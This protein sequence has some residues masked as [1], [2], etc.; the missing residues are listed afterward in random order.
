M[1]VPHPILQR[2]LRL[3]Q[4]C[5]V[6]INVEQRRGRGEPGGET[7][8]LSL[9]FVEPFDSLIDVFDAILTTAP[10]IH[11]SKKDP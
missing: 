4:S 3:L 1:F 11:L 10:C 5:H 9:P 6:A 2:I 8:V 7:L